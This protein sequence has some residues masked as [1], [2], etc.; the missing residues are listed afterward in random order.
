MK[1]SVP[2]GAEKRRRELSKEAEYDG[3][4]LASLTSEI[5]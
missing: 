2:R 3:S 1:R 5:E 4:Y